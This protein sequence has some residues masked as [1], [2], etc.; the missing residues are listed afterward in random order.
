MAKI[1]MVGFDSVEVQLSRLL[2]RNMIRQVVEAGARVAAEE[3]RNNIETA[4]HV[5]TGSMRDN[6]KPG[7]YHEDFGGGY[8][9]VYPQDYDRR[10]TP[11]ALKAFV[12]NYGRGGK[13]TERTGDKFITGKLAR[14]KQVVQEAM[15]AESDRI[16]AQINK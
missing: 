2:D 14:T 13:R 3:M 16:L 8:V 9:D 10:G 12:I 15:Q 11:N 6:V 5:R 7:I 4:R 1:T